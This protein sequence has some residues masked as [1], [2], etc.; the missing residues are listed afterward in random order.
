MWMYTFFKCQKSTGARRDCFG[1]LLHKVSKFDLKQLFLKTINI[2][3]FNLNK[4]IKDVCKMK[5]KLQKV[6]FAVLGYLGVSFFL[7]KQNVTI[8]CDQAFTLIW[9]D[10]CICCKL[11]D[12]NKPS[13]N[14]FISIANKDTGTIY[15]HNAETVK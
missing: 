2:S 10:K 7:L 3:C 12:W 15:M 4:I 5:S 1:L 11:D 13:Q 9:I 8:S 6:Y 14:I